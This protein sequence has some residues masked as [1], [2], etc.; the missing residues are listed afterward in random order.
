MARTRAKNRNYVDK[1]EFFNDMLDWLDPWLISKKDP[2]FKKKL[3]AIVDKKGKF[4]KNT[5]MKKIPLSPLPA[6]IGT[7]IYEIVNRYS[8]RP[9]FINYT[10]KDK[11]VSEA[12]F[13]CIRYANRFSPEISDNPFAYFTRIAWSSFLKCLNEEKKESMIKNEL[14]N[15]DRME[16]NKINTTRLDIIGLSLEGRTDNLGT[17][18]GLFSAWLPMTVYKGKRKRVFKTKAQYEKYVSDNRAKAELSKEP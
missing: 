8:Y 5:W 13:T 7:K 3:K 12:L 4:D 9:N 18:N 2:R 10:Y 6:T 14:Y 17:K 16:N 1:E 15:I 11:M